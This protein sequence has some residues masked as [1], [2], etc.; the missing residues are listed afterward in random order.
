VRDPTGVGPGNLTAPAPVSHSHELDRFDCGH[1]SLDDWLKRMAL[2]SEGSTARTY[3]VCDGAR[4]VGYYAVATGGVERD[5]LPP[6][7]R[8]NT[9]NLVP[10]AI[11]GRLAVDR[12]Y[13]GRGIGPGLLR[14][15]FMRLAGVSRVIGIRAVLV[16][17]IDD[18]AR[19][20]YLKQAEFIEFPAESRTLFLPIET[21]AAA[22]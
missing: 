7:L 15:A 1:Q 13:Q 12:G 6:K 20:F 5:A 17:A 8:R 2:R 18:E 11:I 4:V 16:H 10:V 3:V 19:R 14:D 9:P 21:I 22:M